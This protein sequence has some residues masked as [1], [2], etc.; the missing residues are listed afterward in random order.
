[1]I[2]VYKVTKSFPKEEIYGLVNQVR[3]SV[4]CLSPEP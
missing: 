3:R 2:D 1:M 4:V